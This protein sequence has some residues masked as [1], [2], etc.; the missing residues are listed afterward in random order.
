MKK[1][2]VSKKRK[3]HFSIWF[4]LSF[5]LSFAIFS[6]ILSQGIEENQ[7][8][9]AIFQKGIGKWNMKQIF[10]EKEKSFFFQTVGVYPK[11]ETKMAHY[12][13]IPDPF[14]K[15]EEKNPRIYLYNTHQTEG[16]Q[17]ETNSE[18]DIAPTVLYASYFLREKLNEKGLPCIVETSNITELLNVNGW[19]YNASYKASR[20]LL[21]NA[22]EKNPTLSYFIDI[23]RDSIPYHSSYVTQNE[24]RY[25]KVLFVV[26][27]D[28]DNY[29]KNRDLMEKISERMNQK[30]PQISKGIIEK[31]GSSVNGI[32]NQDFHPHT[33][34]IEIGGEENKFEEIT[35]TLDIFAEALQEYIGEE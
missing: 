28:Y 14:P 35:N 6:V 31:G 25:A 16:Y 10:S 4:T 3:T 29:L 18:H 8:I 23:H 32:Y 15:G 20:Y 24:K 34:L 9:Q 33:I 12:E 27:T 22:L 13:Y 5:L 17:K 11:E 26:G 19:N 30:I 7:M 1:R 21:E 2:F